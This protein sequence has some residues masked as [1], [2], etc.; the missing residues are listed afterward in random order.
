MKNEVKKKMTITPLKSW[1][2]SHRRK[3]FFDECQPFF[4]SKQLCDSE[5]QPIVAL[6]TAIESGFNTRDEFS[7][8]KDRAPALLFA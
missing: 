1:H 3:N 6:I 5:F 2:Q 8:L 7:W 4:C